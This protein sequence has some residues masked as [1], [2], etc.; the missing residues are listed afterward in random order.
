MR[1]Y[2]FW[3]V[4]ILNLV[5]TNISQATPAGDPA[6]PVLLKGTYP[7]KAEGIVDFMFGRDFDLSGD[8]SKIKGQW[9]LGKISVSLKEAIDIYGLLGTAALKVDGWT[10]EDYTLESD[11]ALAWGG[12]L[13]MVLYE[14]EEYGEGTLRVTFDSNCRVYEPGIETVKKSGADVSDVTKKEFKY[15]EWQASLGVSYSLLQYTPYLGV[16]YSDCEAKLRIDDHGTIHEA[17]PNSKDVV[18]VF[19]GI[20]YLFNENFALNLEGRFIDETALNVGL[21][22]SY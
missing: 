2:I 5:W 19:V 10:A 16:K 18:G 6:D 3:S 14:T 1:R 9:Y 22:I 11:L 17:R 21:K 7:I 15:L 4:L 20:D 8:D 12:G 13:K